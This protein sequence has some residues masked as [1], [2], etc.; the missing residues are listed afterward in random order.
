MLTKR[1]LILIKET[2][3]DEFVTKEELKTSTS[4][5]IKEIHSLIEIF[6]DTTQNHEIRLRILEKRSPNKN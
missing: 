6:G 1:D 5:I 3:R 4:V 2:L